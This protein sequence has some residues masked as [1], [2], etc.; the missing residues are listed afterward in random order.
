MRTGSGSFVTTTRTPVRHCALTNQT[1]NKF[2]ATFKK[3][4]NL[5]QRL[6]FAGNK[7]GSWL[8]LLQISRHIQY[9]TRLHRKL[10]LPL[11]KSGRGNDNDMRPNTKGNF[12]WRAAQ[13]FAIHCNV[14]AGGCGA[15]ITLDFLRKLFGRN[16]LRRDRGRGWRWSRRSRW[17]GRRLSLGN[18]SSTGLGGR[19]SVGLGR[20]DSRHHLI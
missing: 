4:F 11:G 3:R 10:A 14:R 5:R 12:G 8:T 20:G 15:E 13:I 9:C 18:R 2:R 16:R 6:H 19:D 17:R 7:S 1:D